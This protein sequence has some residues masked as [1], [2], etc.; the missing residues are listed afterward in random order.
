MHKFVVG[1]FVKATVDLYTGLRE[2][3]CALIPKEFSFPYLSHSSNR[4]ITICVCSSTRVADD[5][6]DDDGD[7]NTKKK[8]IVRTLYTH[9]YDKEYIIPVVPHRR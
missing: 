3:A 2:R 7:N 6:D 9:A 4:C 1:I 8:R 5:D